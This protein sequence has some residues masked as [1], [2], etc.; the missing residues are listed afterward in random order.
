MNL[1]NFVIGEFANVVTG[2]NDPVTIASIAG[3]VIE[4]MDSIPNHPELI[5]GPTDQERIEAVQ[6][7]IR[8]IVLSYRSKIEYAQYKRQSPGL[9]IYIDHGANKN[10]SS[11]LVHRTHNISRMT[12]DSAAFLVEGLR[13]S[14]FKFASHRSEEIVDVEV[15]I[16]F[17]KMFYKSRKRKMQQRIQ[18]VVVLQ[19][20]VP[21]QQ[22]LEQTP[23]HMIYID[24]PGN[25]TAVELELRSQT[26][27][28]FEMTDACAALIVKNLNLKGY[29][30]V[31]NQYK[32]V[33]R[34]DIATRFI[35]KKYFPAV[36]RRRQNPNVG[37][38]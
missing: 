30:F 29:S 4:W 33:V 32:V 6:D 11:E 10:K 2:I 5:V 7:K 12:D 28:N 22:L 14:G 9:I 37:E 27:Y 26:Q 35:V 25:N 31:S 3:S 34:H 23:N 13:N 1:L 17:I 24:L 38:D 16:K 8:D 18:P 15:A 19:P 20:Q 36:L 21:F